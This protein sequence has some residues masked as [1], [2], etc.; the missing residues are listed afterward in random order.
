MSH[1]IGSHHRNVIVVLGILYSIASD[2]LSHIIYQFVSNF[3]T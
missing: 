1:C 3:K 2:L